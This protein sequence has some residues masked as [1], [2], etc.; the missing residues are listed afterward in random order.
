MAAKN[1]LNLQL[2]ANPGEWDIENKLF[3]ILTTY[4]PQDSALSSEQAAEQINSLFPDNRPGD[5]E[6][7][8]SGSF[9][10]EFWDLMVRIAY[11]LDYQDVPMQRFIG[12]MKALRQLPSD[13]MLK[14][15]LRLWQDLPSF[16]MFLIERW[17]R[18]FVSHT[19]CIR[20]LNSQ[21]FHKRLANYSLQEL[22]PANAS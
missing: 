17:N 4:L 11:Q 20:R 12:L 6:K 22:T 10:A 9:L 18:T 16:S 13:I 7:E 5:E 3:D 14:D 19:V 15:G 21:T 1:P 2:E 8:S